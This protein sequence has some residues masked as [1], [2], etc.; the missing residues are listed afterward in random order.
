MS[1]RWK[2][3]A[4][5]HLR[6]SSSVTR[7]SSFVPLLVVGLLVAGAVPGLGAGPGEEFTPLYNG[8]DLSG[9]HAQGG[10]LGAWKADGDL[11]ACVRPGGGWLTT[12]R[13]YGDFV[14]RVQWRIPK[15]GNSG[16]GLRCPPQGDP[17]H[18]AMEIQILDD[19][20]PEYRN[21]DPAQYTGSIYY[22]VAAKRGVEKPPG[23]W[24]QYE[25]TCRGP[26]VTVVLN[27]ETVTHAFLDRETQGRGGHESLAERYR[28]H[29]RGF[30]GLQSH[31]DRV[32]FRYVEIRE[33][34]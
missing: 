34:G 8:K 23:E 29:P 2:G 17:A 6:H 5:G 1:G 16:I 12:D 33:L 14:L 31:G 19:D 28:K 26:E 4:M 27:G 11:L 10:S 13:E 18:V 7:H 24:N 20:A 9:W 30:V 32:D 25:I 22:Q 21:L 15:S 3:N